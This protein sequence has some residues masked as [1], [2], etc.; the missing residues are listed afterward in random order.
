MKPGPTGLS[1]SSMIRCKRELR[2]DNNYHCDD[3]FHSI[4][5]FEALSV[6][7]RVA[8]RK[9]SLECDLRLW[10]CFEN[11]SKRN[12]VS[13]RINSG[14][15]CSFVRA[16][17]TVCINVVWFTLER[18]MNHKRDWMKYLI[19][20]RS[21]QFSLCLF[22]LLNLIKTDRKKKNFFISAFC[23]TSSSSWRGKLARPN[24]INSDK[25]DFFCY[26]KWIETAFDGAVAFDFIQKQKVSI[27]FEEFKD[28]FE[29]FWGKEMI[30]AEFC[31]FPDKFGV[32]FE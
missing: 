25:I 21:I 13:H 20:N 19:E 28:N 14:D 22:S 5:I 4:F 23:V 11:V 10:I 31:N 15:S 32:Y 2:T 27:E 12:Y 1:L 9:F 16:R 29:S 8:K 18:L 17:I 24:K 3:N 6:L 7:L 30:I 26:A